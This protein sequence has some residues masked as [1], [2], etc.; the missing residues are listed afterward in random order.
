LDP[1]TAR[2][3]HDETLPKEAHK[4]AHFCSMC[5]PKFCSMEITQQVRDYASK[6]NERGVELAKAT[7]VVDPEAAQGSDPAGLTPSEAQ[8]GMAEMSRKF[9]DLGGE[10][11]VDADKVKAANKA[12]G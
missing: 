6:L 3:M 9:R 12:L 11:Y 2:R 5:G 8:A 10:V 7:T 4:V 1:D